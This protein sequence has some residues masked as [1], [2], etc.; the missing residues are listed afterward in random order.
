M[1]VNLRLF[2][3][4]RKYQLPTS[5]RY[6]FHLYRSIA[7][8]GREKQDVERILTVLRNLRIGRTTLRVR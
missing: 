7:R 3:L 8:T 1:L 4:F 5:V 2:Q 6:D